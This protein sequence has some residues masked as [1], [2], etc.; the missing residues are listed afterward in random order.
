MIPARLR[1]VALLL[2]LAAPL[3]APAAAQDLPS[4]PIALTPAQRE[5]AL[6]AG[7]ERAPDAGLPLNGGDHR[8]H[9]EIGVTLGTG[10]T[11]S[12]YGAAGLPLGDTG[13]AAFAFERGRSNL[14]SGRCRTGWY[15]C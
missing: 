11:R 7:A 6:N 9:G 10:G 14:R 5:A 2:A 15:E 3:A 4:A 12:I 8:V 1:A 13:T